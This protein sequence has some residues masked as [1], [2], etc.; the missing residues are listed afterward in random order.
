MQYLKIVAII[1]EPVNS[2][3]LFTSELVVKVNI[4]R[5]V[6]LLETFLEAIL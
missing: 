3:Q 6:T 4:Y 1:T 5:T 2:Y